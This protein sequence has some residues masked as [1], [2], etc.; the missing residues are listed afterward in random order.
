MKKTKINLIPDYINTTPDYYCTWQ[1]QL[2]ATC[3]GKPTGQRGAINENSLFT[4][5]KPYGWAYFYERVR[6]DLFIVLDDGW[7]V[8]MIDNN[9]YYGSLILNDEKFPAFTNNSKTNTEALKM[10]SDKI[11]S[12][13]W[14]GLGVWVCCQECEKYSDNID[15]EEYWIRKLKE[16]NDAEI[17]YWKVD[18]GKNS[19]D[20]EFRKM[21]TRLGKEYA[22]DL[23]IEHAVNSDIIPY[24][25]TFRTYDVPAIMSIPMTIEKL[26]NCM[27]V[28]KA[29]GD[30]SGLINCEDEVYIAAAGGFAMGIMRH[31]YSGEFT[32]GH[33]D[34][35]FPKIH[36]NLKTK[37]YEVV[38][39]VNWHKVAPAF[40]IDRKNINIDENELQDNW[41]IINKDEEIE[42]WWF[43]MPAFQ[44]DLKDDVITK[45]A[46][47]RISRNCDLPNVIADESGNIPFVISSKNPNGVFSVVTLGRTLGR[48]YEIPKCNVYINTEE[49]TTVAAFGE[50][51][52]LIIETSYSEINSVLMQD[53]AD[54]I[55][56][57]VTESVVLEKNRIVIPGTV[58]AEIGT[59][60]QP[61]EDTSEPGV[62]ISLDVK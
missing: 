44:K 5:E 35:S 10:L 9:E 43:D 41:H 23:T 53:L 18:W 4:E 31:P 40:G 51:K 22:P 7:D 21:L 38:R 30:F 48:K 57:D 61:P 47:A 54:Y 12:L 42:A 14:K 49:S 8:P 3:D 17:G 45:S 55:A 28:D 13:G 27:S 6:K 46:P 25:D 2:Y 24:S 56:Y 39:A 52:N 58:I 20:I 11:K 32:N 62:I 16:A 15:R 60:S 34:M 19:Y 50:Y 26:K 59:I 33:A 37:M 36:R 29:K 1:T